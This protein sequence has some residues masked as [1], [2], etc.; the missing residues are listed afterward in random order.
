MTASCLVLLGACV[1]DD[2]SWKQE[3][4]AQQKELDAQKKELEE[5]K[6]QHET[7]ALRM[8][9]LQKT[10][11]GLKK[12]DT[13]FSMVLALPPADTVSKG[14]DFT[15]IL[16]VNP[17]GVA[18][19]KDMIA[20]DYI[21]GKQ[22][23]RVEPNDTKASY[24]K[25]SAYFG[26]KDFEADKNSGGEALD[27]QYLVTLTTK[28][29]EAVWDD[30]RMAFVG[31][32]V[33]KEAKT[34][35]V[36]SDPF[37]T[38][39]MPLPAEGLSPWIYPHASFLIEEKKKD[40]KGNEYIEERFGAVYLPLDGVLFKTKDDSDG[41]FYTS[42]NLS[43]IVFEPD[44]GCEAAVKIDF[45]LK[46]RYVSFEPDTTGNLAWRAFRDSTGVKRQEVKGSV[47]MKDRWG[48]VSAYHV[49]MYWYNTYVF[50]I[51]IE[52]TVDQIK[53]GIPINFNEEVKKMGLDYEIMQNCRRVSAFPVH[54]LFND[55]AYEPFDDKKPEEGELILYATP[56]SGD[57]YQT[58][59]IRTVI[60]NASEVDETFIP[61]T[62]RFKIVVNLTIK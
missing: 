46:K 25:K 54:R 56:K 14:L 32:Y 55:L 6:K 33:D 58:E 2:L 19:T 10:I 17:S 51:N 26:L 15:S 27:G 13:P 1:S 61:L 21:A 48:G 50:P 60:V 47:V 5:Q 41:R 3:L 38:V 59:E 12:S 24:V 30:S 28:A 20:L 62:V 57:K 23:Y 35:M 52:A 9:E 22:F 49:I 29:E 4:E 16:R 36:S 45:D 18:L 8:A 42:Q 43:D 53:A 40:D 31:A 7:D 34:Q 37:N 39:M 44:E 11:D